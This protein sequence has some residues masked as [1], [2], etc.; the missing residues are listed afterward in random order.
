MLDLVMPGM[1]GLDVLDHIKSTYPQIPVV[2]LSSVGQIKT[3][4]DAM[5]RG[6]SDYL[7]KPVQEAELTIALESALEKQRLRDEVRVRRR[8]LAP[9]C[10]PPS[11]P[12]T[13][14]T[15][16]PTSHAPP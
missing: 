15:F 8:R 9:F 11:L 13:P 12:P 1:S 14:H 5:N 2:I 7:V 16:P 6:A 10:P 4:V 3:V